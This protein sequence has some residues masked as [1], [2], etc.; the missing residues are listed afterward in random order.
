M[1]SRQ[2]HARSTSP[3]CPRCRNCSRTHSPRG[4]SQGINEL[5][6]SF[7]TTGQRLLPRCARQVNIRK[8]LASLGSAGKP[9]NLAGLA[10]SGRQ[11]TVRTAN[12]ARA[13]AKERPPSPVL[14]SACLLPPAARR[15]ACTSQCGL[16]FARSML[17]RMPSV[18]ACHEA[19]GRPSFT[20]PIFNICGAGVWPPEHETGWCGSVGRACRTGILSVP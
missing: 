5:G 8:Y 12:A 20:R 17:G 11:H 10:G 3:S 9:H 1:A 13:R 6:P 4:R 2:K 14:A 18:H 19:S 7:F 15:C 16:C